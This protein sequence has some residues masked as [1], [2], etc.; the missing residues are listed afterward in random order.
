MEPVLL[1]DQVAAVLGLIAQRKP[2]VQATQ[3]RLEQ[4]HQFLALR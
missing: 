4:R 2:V 1:A 3:A